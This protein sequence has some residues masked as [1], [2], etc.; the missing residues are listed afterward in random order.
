MVV[1]RLRICRAD[2]ECRREYEKQQKCEGSRKGTVMIMVSSFIPLPLSL[3]L[4]ATMA[5]FQFF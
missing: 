3:C 4:P 5:A 2:S 1:R